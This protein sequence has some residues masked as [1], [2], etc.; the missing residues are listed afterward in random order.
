MSKSFLAQRKSFKTAT[1]FMDKNLSIL[2][3]EMWMTHFVDCAPLT[4]TRCNRFS[5]LNSA[6]AKYTNYFIRCV[7]NWICVFLF[8]KFSATHWTTEMISSHT[9]FALC[10]KQRNT[11]TNSVAFNKKRIYFPRKWKP[12]KTTHFHIKYS[13]I[14]L[15]SALCTGR[16]LCISIRSK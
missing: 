6:K 14:F 12:M 13:L 2:R 7:T 11:K 3:A 16:F 10:L 5:K 15:P 9:L 4:R 8:T 1:Q